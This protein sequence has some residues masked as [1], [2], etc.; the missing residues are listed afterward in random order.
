[1]LPLR[2]HGSGICGRP[3]WLQIASVVTLSSIVSWSVLALAIFFMLSGECRW[4]SLLRALIAF[5]A[6]SLRKVAV[7]EYLFCG[8][9]RVFDQIFIFR[10]ID[11]VS[12][13]LQVKVFLA[14]GGPEI[15]SGCHG[16]WELDLE[17]FSWQTHSFKARFCETWMNHGDYEHKC[18]QWELGRSTD[19]GLCY[20]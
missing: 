6:S 13:F 7:F 8:L 1:M 2:L 5:S 9:K 17:I 20:F 15:Y 4:L 19:K 18:T 14:D 10:S 16:T 12:N 11:L 3:I